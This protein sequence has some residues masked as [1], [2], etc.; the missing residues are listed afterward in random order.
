MSEELTEKR[1]QKIEERLDYWNKTE[2]TKKNFNKVAFEILGVAVQGNSEFPKCGARFTLNEGYNERGDFKQRDAPRANWANLILC[3]DDEK[4]KGQLWK[5]FLLVIRKLYKI[6][7]GR[8]L[9]GIAGDL[10]QLLR[11]VKKIIK[12]NKDWA[13]MCISEINFL[14]H[15]MVLHKNKLAFVKD[16]EQL[17]QNVE[18]LIIYVVE[19]TT[20]EELKEDYWELESCIKFYIAYK[21]SIPS[22][23]KGA[24]Q[25][26]LNKNRKEIKREREMFEKREQQLKK[27]STEIRKA[28]KPKKG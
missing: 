17:I 24:A 10:E 3:I 23:L 13:S 5:K 22:Q 1:I 25:Y 11:G 20:P 19:L 27:Y 7:G 16:P 28:L 4:L 15:N 26:I 6:H 18:E 8:T 12:D 14:T 21:N 9:L 2:I